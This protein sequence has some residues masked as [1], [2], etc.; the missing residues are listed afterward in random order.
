AALSIANQDSTVLGGYCLRC[1]SP[2]G[3]VRGHTE[4]PD[5]SMLHTVDLQAACCDTRHRTGPSP[6]PNQPYHVGGPIMSFD[7]NEGKHGKDSDGVSPAHDTVPD[8]GV[9]SPRFCGQCHQVTNPEKHLLDATGKDTGK[10]FPFET[11]FE[12]WSGSAYAV[13]NGP[14]AKGC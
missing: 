7:E 10:D 1:H 6:A 5:G 3:H 14:D 2:I 8:Q 11:T 4:P 9:L 13:T 12:E